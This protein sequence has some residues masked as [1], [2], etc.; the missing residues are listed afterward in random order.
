MDATA[1][2]LASLVGLSSAAVAT[3]ARRG[4]MI[5]GD[6]GKFNLEA[7]VRAY[8]QHLREAAAGRGNGT[9]PTEQSTQRARLVR[10]QGT[11][12]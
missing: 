8:C 11:R 5:R 9:E 4:V 1:E 2:Q 7:S 10:A 12:P 3:L 6:R